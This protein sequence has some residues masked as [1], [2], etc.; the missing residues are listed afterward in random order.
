ML[1]RQHI[2]MM[3]FGQG[4]L[5]ADVLDGDV[6]VVLLDLLVDCSLHIFMLGAGDRLVCNGWRYYLVDGGVMM[7]SLGPIEASVFD[8]EGFHHN[9]TNIKS[10]TAALAASIE[11]VLRAG[12]EMR[13]CVNARLPL[14]AGQVLR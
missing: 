14:L 8:R 13:Y 3:L 4:S 1:D 9:P 12:G 2:G 10:C 5:F 11:L 7:T 6:I